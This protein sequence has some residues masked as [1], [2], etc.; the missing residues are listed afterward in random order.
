M[1]LVPLSLWSGICSG[2]RCTSKCISCGSEWKCLMVLQLFCTSRIDSFI[3]SITSLAGVIYDI[4]RGRLQDN[5]IEFRTELL[6]VAQVPHLPLYLTHDLTL[7]LFYFKDQDADWRSHMINLSLLCC[8]QPLN[9]CVHLLLLLLMWL[10][11]ISSVCI[12]KD[13]LLLI[14]QI[15]P[16]LIFTAIKINPN[17]KLIYS[18]FEHRNTH[19][20]CPFWLH[21]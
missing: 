4:M 5:G 17:L 9:L 2:C 7:G 3:S 20:S 10:E 8:K 15:A 14:L 18:L 16:F 13:N 11:L 1:A 6:T 19:L 21:R 12:L